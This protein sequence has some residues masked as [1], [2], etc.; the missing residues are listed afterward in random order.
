MIKYHLTAVHQSLDQGET[1]REKKP[2]SMRKKEKKVFKGE[3]PNESIFSRLE[4]AC[5]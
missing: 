4:G 2:S 3:V 1:I 5:P